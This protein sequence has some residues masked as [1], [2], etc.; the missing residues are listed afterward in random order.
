MKSATAALLSDP[1]FSR[2]ADTPLEICGGA[3]GRQLDRYATIT[4]ILVGHYPLTLDSAVLS[5]FGP[6]QGLLHQKAWP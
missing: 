3:H 6:S 4:P 1:S 5:L 2:G